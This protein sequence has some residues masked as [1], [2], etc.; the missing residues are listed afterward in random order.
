MKTCPYCGENNAID[1]LTC[2]FC[3]KALAETVLLPRPQEYRSAAEL[4]GLPLV[5]YVQGVDPAT[6]KALVAK[7]IIAI[8]DIAFGVLFAMG[9]VAY[10]GIAVGGVAVGVLAFGGMALGVF[11]LGG[12]AVALFLAVGGMAMSLVYAL[13]GLA[14]APFAGGGN[15]M[16]P[17]ILQL[18]NNPGEALKDLWRMLSGR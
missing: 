9:G 6:G 8:G 4:F 13:G 14:L 17:E 16:D 7:G 10:G 11:A 18:M 2:R 12:M 3:G 5:H 15:R 1:D